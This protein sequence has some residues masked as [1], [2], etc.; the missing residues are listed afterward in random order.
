MEQKIQIRE[1]TSSGDARGFSFTAPTDA[2]TFVG[3]MSDVHL[4]STKPGAIRGNHYHLRRREAIV[5]LPGAKWSL[6]WD[7]GQGSQPQHREFDG[8]RAVLV[9]VSPGA[10]HAVR[11]DGESELLLVAISSETYDPAESVARKVV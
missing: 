4:A 7:E 1:L 6:H 3:R 10:S 8:T 5:V 2:L 9:L 11:N